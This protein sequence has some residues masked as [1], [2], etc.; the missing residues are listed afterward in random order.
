MVEI[1]IK[2]FF[3]RIDHDWLLRMLEQR[4]DDRPLLRL[5]RKW[6]KAGVLE[7]DGKV[8]HPD[9]GKPARR[10]ASRRCWPTSIFTTSWTC[11]SQQG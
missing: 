7:E 3:D 11:G 10:E 5:I 9:D 4:I 2:G 8:I 1:D 6:L